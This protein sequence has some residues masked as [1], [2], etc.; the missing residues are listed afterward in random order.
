MYNSRIILVATNVSIPFKRESVSQAS[1]NADIDV[2]E[3]VSIP[4]KRESV[5]QGIDKT[6]E[7]PF[8]RVSIPFKRESVSQENIDSVNCGR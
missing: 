7:K 1:T 4:F 8:V 5:S 6:A 2:W 3:N